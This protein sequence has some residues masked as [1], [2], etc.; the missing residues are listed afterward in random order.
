MNPIE[1]VLRV[2]KDLACSLFQGRT[3]L[4]VTLY[5]TNETY[6]FLLFIKKKKNLFSSPARSG[7]RRQVS[8]RGVQLDRGSETG[9]RGEKSWTQS[10]PGPLFSPRRPQRHLMSS[11][12]EL[13]RFWGRDCVLVRAIAS[14][15]SR[16]DGCCSLE[17]PVACPAPDASWCS[18][19]RQLGRR[20]IQLAPNLG[21]LINWPTT[22]PGNSP[23]TSCELKLEL[24]D[25]PPR[26]KGKK[27]FDRGDQLWPY[28]STN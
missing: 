15:H 5:L 28:C 10:H 24:G 26:K 7:Q 8:E 17:L 13:A 22:R 16:I 23:S 6:R 1:K 18:A 3:V 11:Q 4:Q 25:A 20:V 21:Q 9:L 14:R 2:R 27:G 19:S 12:P